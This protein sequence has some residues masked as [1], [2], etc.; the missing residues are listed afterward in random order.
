MPSWLR[1]LT[2]S[3]RPILTRHRRYEIDSFSDLHGIVAEVEPVAYLESNDKEVTYNQRPGR[4]K[5]PI[6]TLKR[7]EE[8]EH[9]A[10]GV[11]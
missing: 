10:L 7:G 1:L 9:G 6:V 2:P 8:R 5:P 4:H 11:A 3:R